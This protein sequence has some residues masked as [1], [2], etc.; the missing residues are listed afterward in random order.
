MTAAIAYCNEGHRRLLPIAYCNETNRRP[1]YLQAETRQPRWHRI[2]LPVRGL[3]E[4][5]HGLDHPDPR[6]DLHRP[7]DQRLSA[8]R[9][10]IR[11]PFG[12][13]GL[14]FARIDAP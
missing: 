6:R 12:L 11:R 5:C 1:P 3:M 7:R 14:M 2:V 9:V 8:G 13:K 10:L 4:E